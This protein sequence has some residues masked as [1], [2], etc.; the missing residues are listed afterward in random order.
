LRQRGRVVQRD[1]DAKR[2][3]HGMQLVQRGRAGVAGQVQVTGL[4]KADV[5]PLVADRQLVADLAIEGQAGA[6]QRDV[7][8][9]GELLA[10]RTRRQRARRARVTRVA[11]E[12][13]GSDAVI[14]RQET[15]N[16][17]AHDAAADDHDA[18]RGHRATG[19][20]RRAAVRRRSG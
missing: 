8:G 19:C 14:A 18:R 17:R 15:R 4:D 11:L 20:G 5:R 3:L 9:L 2:T 12:H 10:D 6:R 7:D 16:G 1:I 13:G